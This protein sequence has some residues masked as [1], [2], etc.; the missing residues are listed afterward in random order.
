MTARRAAAK[1]RPV[2]DRAI[3]MLPTELSW[4]RGIGTYGWRLLG[5]VLTFAPTAALYVLALVITEFRH[6]PAPKTAV[7]LGT[8]TLVAIAAACYGTGVWV[9]N[10]V[11]H[12]PREVR[13]VLA[14]FVAI[15]AAVAVIVGVP[16]AVIAYLGN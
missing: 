2:A 8:L 10:R 3:D 11:G 9:H 4:S 14:P 7:A 13:L 16:V 12:M 15:G 1:K 6:H 5:F